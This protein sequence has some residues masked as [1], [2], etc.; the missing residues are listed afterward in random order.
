MLQAGTAI[1]TAAAA[2][3]KRKRIEYISPPWSYG[4]L[5]SPYAEHR[6]EK[7][8]HHEVHQGTRR[9]THI[10]PMPLRGRK[11]IF[12]AK[13]IKLRAPLCSP[14]HLPPGQVSC[15]LPVLAIRARVVQ[16]LRV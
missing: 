8:F 7:N 15:P 4:S 1:K 13:I 14:W 12:W 6:K 10:A 5:N 11:P 2:H 16:A 3:R 9:K